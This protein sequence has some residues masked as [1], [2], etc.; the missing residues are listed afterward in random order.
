VVD[1]SGILVVIS[2]ET[3]RMVNQVWIKE[4]KSLIPEGVRQALVARGMGKFLA[5]LKNHLPTGELERYRQQCD[6]NFLPKEP[7]RLCTFSP[8]GELLFCGTSG[9][10]RGLRWEDVLACHEMQPVP[11]HISVDAESVVLGRADGFSTEHKFVYGIAFDALRQRV[12]FSGLEGKV[13]FLELN[14][15]RSGTLLVSPD[16]APLIQ[17]ALTPNRAA[18][19]ATSHRFDIESHKQTASRFQIW[20]YG[21]LCRAVGLEH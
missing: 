7:I 19:V 2:L 21:A 20:N 18:L 1:H 17:L 13:T 3:M 6:R 16:K 9:G 12:L 8:D 4:V 14:N 10:L 15:R 5:E 11:V